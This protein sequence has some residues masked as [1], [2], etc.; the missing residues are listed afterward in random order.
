MNRNEE[1]DRNS[2]V[3]SQSN[4]PPSHTESLRFTD[5][6]LPTKYLKLTE[7]QHQLLTSVTHKKENLSNQ[8]KNALIHCN[9]NNLH[10]TNIVELASRNIVLRFYIGNLF[11][12]PYTH[13][14]GLNDTLLRRDHVHIVYSPP[15]VGL[16]RC[17]VTL[18]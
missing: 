16:Q 9:P 8:N 13:G 2:T 10:E 1:R 17:I 3:I 15:E 14:L 4:I 18:R 5:I 11:I 12:W 6:A 7:I